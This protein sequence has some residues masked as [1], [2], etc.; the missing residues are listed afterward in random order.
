VSAAA[1]QIH[2]RVAVHVTWSLPDLRCL[3]AS[4]S[5][6]QS[7]ARIWIR[8]AVAAVAPNRFA[9]GWLALP[10]RSVSRPP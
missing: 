2:G 10:R 9:V 4:A 6:P 8:S 7:N 3:N 5:Q 1:D